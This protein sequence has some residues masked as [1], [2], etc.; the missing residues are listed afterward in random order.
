MKRAI[1]VIVIV[2]MFGYAVYEFVDRDK[3]TSNDGDDE[4]ITATGSGSNENQNSNNEEDSSSHATEGNNAQ[5]SDDIAPEPG[6]EQG[7]L[8]PDFELELLDSGETVKLSDF[9]GE[10][11]LLNFWASW[12]GPCRAEMPDMEKLHN[13]EDVVILAVNLVTTETSFEDI[14]DFVEEFGLTFDILLDEENDVANL[15]EIKPIPTSYLI[16][17]DGVIQ[18]MALG[19]INYEMMIQGFEMME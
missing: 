1:I 19:A 4:K 18:N 17:D 16:D 9:R 12:C 15:Y 8:A 6:L 5:E 14:P 11:V 13:N 2:A 3:S 7:D 10:K